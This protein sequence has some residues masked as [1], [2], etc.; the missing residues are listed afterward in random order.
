[1]RNIVYKPN[2]FKLENRCDG[3]AVLISYN[4]FSI[5]MIA[6]AEKCILASEL[7]MK[8][9]NNSYEQSFDFSKL[10][11]NLKTKY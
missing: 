1:M 4:H 10:K 3:I 11:V 2:N 5:N 8:F 7:I 6:T 9:I